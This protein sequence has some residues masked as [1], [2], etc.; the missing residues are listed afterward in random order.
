LSRARGS[1][2]AKKLAGLLA[3]FDEQHGHEPWEACGAEK[4]P[5]RFHLRPSSYSGKTPIY[6]EADALTECPLR[7]ATAETWRTLELGQ[8][9][10]TDPRMFDAAESSADV[11]EL[12]L[13]ASEWAQRARLKL[14]LGS[15]AHLFVG[16]LRG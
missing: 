2:G 13:S 12:V 9:H 10:A 16:A 1:R 6:D 3:A 8:M 11:A 5:G 7:A 4:A 15:V 14:A